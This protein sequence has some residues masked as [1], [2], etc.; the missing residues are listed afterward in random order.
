MSRKNPKDF[1]FKRIKKLMA[2]YVDSEEKLPPDF[3]FVEESPFHNV[4]Y[5]V[6]NEDLSL[7]AQESSVRPERL[8]K[9]S[10]VKI[11]EDTYY[12]AAIPIYGVPTALYEDYFS[13]R[14]P[15]DC[16]RSPESTLYMFKRKPFGRTKVISS[17][18]LHLMESGRKMALTMEQTK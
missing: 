10:W 7:G 14:S 11:D 15:I 9:I 12:I 3:D 5:E 17:V 2:P 18:Y 16:I 4:V 1:P 6:S 8:E 13:T